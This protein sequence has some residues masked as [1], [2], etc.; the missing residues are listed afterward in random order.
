LFEKGNALHELG[1]YEAA[2]ASWQQALRIQ[3][4]S[5]FETRLVSHAIPMQ[6]ADVLLND[7]KPYEAAL[8]WNARKAE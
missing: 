3:S 2:I 4:K 1:H 6:I 8:L 5:D 7:L